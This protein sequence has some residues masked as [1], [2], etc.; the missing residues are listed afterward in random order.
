MFYRLTENYALRAWK[1]APHGV[2]FRYAENPIRV[3]ADTFELLLLQHF[4]FFLL[5]L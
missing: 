3:D 5:L 2:Y 1:Y 4:Q